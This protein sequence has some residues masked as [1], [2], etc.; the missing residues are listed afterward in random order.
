MA[1]PVVRSTST[2]SRR[3]RAQHERHRL[4]CGLL[5]P[6]LE[7]NLDGRIVSAVAPA[8]L[9]PGDDW[10][11]PRAGVAY[12]LTAGADDIYY[13]HKQGRRE[14]KF[15]LSDSCGARTHA[16]SRSDSP[17]SRAPPA[18]GSTSMNSASSSTRQPTSTSA[19]S[20]TTR[21][22]RR[23]T[24]RG[25]P[26]WSDDEDQVPLAEYKHGPLTSSRPPTEASGSRSQSI[27]RR[28]RCSVAF[29]YAAAMTVPAK[30][31]RPRKW[32]S[33]RGPGAGLPR[34]PA[35]RSGASHPRRRALRRRRTRH[36]RRFHP[37]ASVR[38]CCCQRRQEG[39]RGG[40][41]CRKAANGD[42]T[43]KARS[44]T[45][46]TGHSPGVQWLARRGVEWT[47]RA[48]RDTPG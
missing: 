10:P 27:T 48:D 32:R 6:A 24:S 29:R 8:G 5:R 46:G 3:H 23:L 9:R 20:R 12:V 44:G 16:T 42:G 37:S 31:G 1:Y 17:A 7:F 45:G 14:T 28:V 19:P 33:G 26:N 22:S 35:R 13:K 30:G 15:Y 34:S 4:L 43:P 38:T 36:S 11:G 39:H 40:D 25:A 41:R 2:S 18:G 21:G 47:R